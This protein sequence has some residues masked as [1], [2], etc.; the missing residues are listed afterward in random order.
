MG[1]E[2]IEAIVQRARKGGIE[3][4]NLLK[5]G[6]AFYAPSAGAVEMAEAIINLIAFKAAGAINGAAILPSEKEPATITEKNSI[7]AWPRMASGLEG[8]KG[9]SYLQELH[10]LGGQGVFR[11]RPDARTNC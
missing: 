10:I 2:Q 1:A 9:Q 6:S 8:V 3:I 7:A 11:C 4:V 5:T